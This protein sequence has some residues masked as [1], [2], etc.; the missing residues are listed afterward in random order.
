MTSSPPTPAAGEHGFLARLSI[1]TKLISAFAALILL[2]GGLGAFALNRVGAVR[3]IAVDIQTN[4]LPSV[5]VIGRLSLAVADHRFYVAVSVLNTGEANLRLAQDGLQRAAARVTALR[6]DYELL[7]SSP[8]ERR[9]AQRFD[10]QL[11]GY[12]R[13]AEAALSL[14]RRNAEPQARQLLDEKV[15]P[16]FQEARSTLTAITELNV[17]GS[18]A[19]GDAGAETYRMSVVLVI[20]FLVATILLGTIVAWTMIRDIGRNISSLVGSMQAM[21]GGDLDRNVPQLPEST[22]LGHIAVTLRSFRAVL[23]AK[24]AADQAATTEA[25]AKAARTARVDQLVREFE[26]EAADALRIVASASTE[27]DAIAGEMAGTAQSGVER[28]SSLAAGSE[29]ASANVQT[30]AASAEELAASISEVARRVA[31]SATAARRAAEDARETDKAVGALAEAAG[32]IGDVVRLIGDIA[33]QTNLLALNATIE[34]ARAGEHGKGFAVVASEVKALAGQTAKATDEI[35]QQI[36]QMQSETGRAVEAIKGISRTIEMLNGI[37]A[38]VASA[39]E[40]QA[41]ATQEIGRAVA[42]AAAGTRDVS[43]NAGGLTEVATQTGSAASQ[44]RT[45]AGELAGRAEALRS[46]MG[47][48]L[49]QLRAA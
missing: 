6:A 38:G 39:A 10:Q 24:R 40:Q 30:V 37:S 49:G 28:A 42:E 23:I 11:A 31:E 33:N 7:I 18:T 45:A 29:Q 26:A 27:L 19:A 14:V 44:V 15:N 34:A 2:A 8:E 32:R 16:A 3:A 20:T 13:E 4:W 46:Q 1:R 21:E 35:S 48:F 9:L 17:A 47:S 43:N 22:E 41:A 12:Y 25:Q 5:R 36:A